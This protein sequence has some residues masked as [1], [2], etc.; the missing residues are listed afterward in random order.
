MASKKSIIA[1]K[2]QEL[3][4]KSDWQAA[5]A[6]MERLF[7]IDQDPHVRVRIGNVQRKLN[8]MNDAIQDYVYA[9]ELFAERGFAVKALAQYNLVLKLDSSNEYARSQRETLRTR[10]L[11]NDLKREPVEY[12]LSQ[13]PESDQLFLS[14]Y[15]I[16][17]MHSP[18][19]SMRIPSVHIDGRPTSTGRLCPLH[20]EYQGDDAE[21]KE[22]D[23]EKSVCKSEG[24]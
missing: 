24:R 6:E 10:R 11:F 8:R 19:I 20:D 9:A 21:N 13:Q 17:Q 4:D 15:T 14:S 18:I 16:P 22:A 7:A 12:R 23:H 5:I 2:V 3:L 1:G